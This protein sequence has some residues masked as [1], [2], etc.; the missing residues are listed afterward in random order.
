MADT[1]KNKLPRIYCLQKKGCSYNI[2]CWFIIMLKSVFFIEKC[3]YVNY[4]YINKLKTR[5]KIFFCI[6][7]GYVWSYLSQNLG[8]ISAM[9]RLYKR[10]QVK[11][12]SKSVENEVRWMIFCEILLF[13][14]L[15]NS[16]QAEN[17]SFKNPEVWAKEC[18]W[19]NVSV[20]FH[21]GGW[22]EEV[23]SC[24]LN[25]YMVYL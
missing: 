4:K 25:S 21:C 22:P 12:F 8:V 10:K 6:K 9:E 7:N 19:Q 16:I 11:K 15:M 18:R 20:R 1:C 14:Y 5:L 13:T 24:F 23:N 17:Q 2:S 3:S